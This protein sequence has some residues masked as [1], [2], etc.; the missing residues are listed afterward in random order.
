MLDAPRR[1]RFIACGTSRLADPEAALAEAAAALDPGAAGLV[2]MLAPLNAD[3]A[4]LARAVPAALPGVPVVGAVTPGQIT[5]LGYETGTLALLALPRAHFRTAVLRIPDLDRMSIKAVTDAVQARDRAFR[6]AQGTRR[7]AICLADGAARKE[8]ML[9]STLSSALGDTEVFGGSTGAVF[10]EGAFHGGAALCL[11]VETDL[12]V[13]GT[14]FTHVLPTEQ[15]LVATDAVPERRLVRELNGA[16]AATEYAR[17]IGCRPADLGPRV[18]ADNP[19]LVRHGAQH[20]VRAVAAVEDG[21]ALS[22][23]ASID[24]GEILTLG[25]GQGIVSAL[26]TGLDLRTGTGAEPDFVLGFDCI[27]RRIEIGQKA[28]ESEVS[29]I[30][31]R[32]RVLGMNTLGE[33]YC[34]R[35]LNQTFVGLAFYPPQGNPPP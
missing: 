12:R 19:I 32:H 2:L 20:F 35:H 23:L 28:L 9:I 13:F 15:D 25:R 5:P 34:G 24:D 18:F 22:F 7:L 1:P 33:Q 29:A 30:F 14:G 16:P 21:D 10:H 6:R 11:L 8:E 3:T 17:L 31:R 27:L 26:E 4:A